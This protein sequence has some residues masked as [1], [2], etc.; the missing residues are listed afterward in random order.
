MSRLCAM[1][2]RIKQATSS[3]RAGRLASAALLLSGSFVASRLLGVLRNTVIAFSFGGGRATDAYFAAF[4]IPDT[5]FTLVSG[6][7]LATAFVPTFASLLE[8]DRD[9]EAWNLASTVLNTVFITFAVLAGVAFVFAPLIMGFFVGATPASERDLTIDL[10]RIM[11]LQPIF[12]GVAAILSSILQTYHRFAPTALAPLIYNIAVITGA[13]VFR[14]HGVSALAVAVV[15]G[16]FLYLLVQIPPMRFESRY[17]LS[18]DWHSPQALEVLGLLGPRVAGLAAF[19]A[20]LFITL[21]LAQRLPK[22][23]ISAINYSWLLIQ[24]PIGTLGTAAATAI[25]PTLS[26]LSAGEDFAAVRR[27]V[28]R[29]L[30]FVLFLS[31]PAAVG[32]IVARRPIINLLYHHGKFTAQNTEQTA[33]ALLFYALALAPL[34]AIEVLPRVFYAMKDTRTPVRIAV[35]A[36]V[37]D[38]AL[39]ILFVSI[40]PRTSGQGGL[41][42][43]TA[44]AST[45]QAVWLALALEDRLD[46]IGRWS[47]LLALRDAAIASLAMG[48]VLYVVL[49]GLTA[50][51]P[52]HGIGVFIT[53]VVEVG[54]GGCV[55]G[56]VSYLLGAPELWQVR[57]FLRR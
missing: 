32:L 42:L 48:V 50:A 20:M 57:A 36:V 39:S 44:I 47:L 1:T 52:Q 14:S 4:R 34:A 41:A 11:L 38:A 37:I 18:F 3:P 22:G 8:R 55:F 28:N 12:L 6:A 9:D 33:F 15:V 25:F 2:A 54:L 49:A 26:R 19:Q 5:M 53:V 51:F 23:N 29:S 24:F 31:M 21:F 40:L 46:G 7:A 56:G 10:T 16:A 43:A 45:V 27:T 17:S 13:Y 35:V 30:R